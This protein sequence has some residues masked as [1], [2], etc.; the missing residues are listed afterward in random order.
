MSTST[1]LLRNWLKYLVAMILL[2]VG[3]PAYAQDVQRRSGAAEPD[4]DRTPR[5]STVLGGRVPVGGQGLA[6][7]LRTTGAPV[8]IEAELRL[9]GKVIMSDQQIA[10]P[11]ARVVHLFGGVEVKNFASLSRT[12]INRA[13]MFAPLHFPNRGDNPIFFYRLISYLF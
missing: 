6:F 5:Q 1:Y 13:Q 11:G 9:D 2:T 3:N 10:S 12:R 4:H 7:P 8:W